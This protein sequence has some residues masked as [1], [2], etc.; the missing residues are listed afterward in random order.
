MPKMF[1]IWNSGTHR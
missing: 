1:I